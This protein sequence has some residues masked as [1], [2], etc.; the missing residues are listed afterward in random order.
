MDQKEVD[1]L[2]K[3]IG[4]RDIII[5]DESSFVGINAICILDDVLQ[6]VGNNKKPFGGFKILWFGDVNQLKCVGDKEIYT[7]ENNDE[8]IDTLL[9]HNNIIEEEIIG[10]VDF[11]K[12]EKDVNDKQREQLYDLDGNRADVPYDESTKN[13]YEEAKTKAGK[14]KKKEWMV[15]KL[16]E[17]VLRFYKL[18]YDYMHKN[19]FELLTSER[20]DK[21]DQN[22][23][24]MMKNLNTK[25]VIKEDL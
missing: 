13:G 18:L 16:K 2:R 25:K 24:E 21:S 14:K 23:I 11:A 1:N 5:V 19:C 15:K 12:I 3:D 7:P 22:H 20:Y 17:V 10:D 4:S 9:E 6:R 8:I